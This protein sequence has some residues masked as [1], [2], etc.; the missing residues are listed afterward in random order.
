M[1]RN[2]STRLLLDLFAGLRTK[3]TDHITIA[4]A[5]ALSWEQDRGLTSWAARVGAPLNDIRC[6]RMQ[7]FK[8]VAF[9]Q[10]EH[11]T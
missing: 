11:N 10:S 1:M 4:S 8:T 5:T 3:M 6:P 9:S 2:V 7:K